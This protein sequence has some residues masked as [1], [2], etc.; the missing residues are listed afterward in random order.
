MV[1]YGLTQIRVLVL[2][3]AVMREQVI[4]EMIYHY[5]QIS[6]TYDSKGSLVAD[7]YVI[8]CARVVYIYTKFPSYFE[9]MISK[10]ISYTF[11]HCVPNFL[12]VSSGTEHVHYAGQL[13]QE[14]SA[15]M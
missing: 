1:P 11:P 14:D 12:L 15:M 2:D 13:S 7:T 5:C 10:T 6:S 3:E 8:N 9:V 4:K